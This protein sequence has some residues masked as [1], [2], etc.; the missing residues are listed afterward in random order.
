[1]KI[2][3]GF[4]LIYLITFAGMLWYNMSHVLV[5]DG[6]KEYQAYLMNIKYGW[7][8]R[9]TLVNSCLITTWIPAL[10]QKATGWDSMLLFRVFPVIFYA[11]M[12]AFTYLI[13]RRY[14]SMKYAIVGVLVVVFNSHILYFPDMGR[15]GVAMGVMSG[16]IWA[17]LEK[18]LIWSIV[19]ALLLVFSHYGTS[20]IAMGLVGVAFLIP[21]VIRRRYFKH[22][23]II[24]CVL[25]VT[26]G[27][28]HFGVARYSGMIM[29]QTLLQTEQT[30]QILSQHPDLLDITTREAAVQAAVGLNISSMPQII[31]VIANWLVV[32]VISLGLYFIVRGKKIE[33][34]FKIMALAF[35]GLILFT[36][37]IP[38]LSV[39]YGAM[40]VYF[41]STVLLAICFPLGAERIARV[42][43][44]APILLMSIVLVLYALVTSGIIYM[45]FGLV[46]TFP[47]M[48]ALP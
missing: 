39:Y 38:P 29:S 16:M 28:W 20:M 21:L 46:K 15:V 25:V 22:Y 7:E 24:F 31:E 32:I 30:G 33:G 4:V 42:L 17:L 11:L 12:P 18:R 9:Q 37:I 45:P 41:A 5:N 8:F 47:V 27:V 26:V 34:Q 40:R 23:L 13:A 14:L 10:I 36:I 35:W 19:F 48:M 2:N 44:V 1:M 43:H 6:V 3:K